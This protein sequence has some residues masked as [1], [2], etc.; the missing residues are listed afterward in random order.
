L[1][2]LQAGI[3]GLVGGV[4]VAM[5]MTG[6]ARRRATLGLIAGVAG[7]ALAL[8]LSGLG[9]FKAPGIGLVNTGPWA[10]PAGLLGMALIGGAGCWALAFLLNG[11]R[12]RAARRAVIVVAGLGVAAYYPLQFVFVGANLGRIVLCVAALGLTGA[13]VGYLLGG[14]DRVTVARSGALAGLLVALLAV[15]DRIMRAWPSYM[16]DPRVRGRAIAT[17]GAVTPNLKG[18]IWLHGL[19][20]ATHLFL[21]TMVLVM[22]GFAAYTRFERAAMLEVLNSD[23][24]RTARAKGLDER[25]VV[26]RHAFRSALIPLA[27]LVPYD[28]AGM[29]GGA[30]I[31][32]N[33]F[34][35]ESV[36][37]F[38]KRSLESGDVNGVMSVVLLSAL[39]VVLCN[40]VVDLLYAWLD[41][42]IKVAT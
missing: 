29:I 11:P 19:D 26:L 17:T 15:A 30:V 28:I 16:A 33:V 23:Y 12:H 37:T 39:T 3:F 18:S 9:W 6:R 1:S 5:V 8:L 14:D 38:F 24:V 35:W 25:V 32:E 34:A 4:L 10:V 36:G 22:I 42:R 2:L 40:I 41:P 31:V 7:A 27:T 13:V 21:P 20:I